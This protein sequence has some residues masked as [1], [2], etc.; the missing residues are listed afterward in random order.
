[1]ERVDVAVVGAGVIGSAAARS[2]AARGVAGVL[3][4][5]FALGHARGSSHGAN[6]V[7]RFSYPDPD[8]VRMAV[9]AREA[10]ARLQADAGEELLLTTGGLDAGPG[11][12]ACAAALAGCGVECHWLGP[13]DLRARF[14]GIAAGPG[15]RMLFQPRAG[16]C[17]AG[18]TVAALQRLAR[19]D[20][21]TS[22]PGTAV[23]AIE[24]E[25]G[26][27]TLRTPAGD[28][29]ARTAIVAAGP[30]S[31]QLLTGA[32]ARA[33]RLTPTVQQVRYFRPRPGAGRWPVL[34]EWPED[35]RVWYTVPQAGGAPGVKVAAHAPGPP[36]DPRDGPFGRIDPAPE[37]AAAG[38]VRERLPGL[39]PVPLAAETCL[40]TMTAD[41]DFVLGRDGQVVV[42]AGCSGH[43]FKFGPLLGEVLAALAL[44]EDP[45]VPL[46]RFALS[47]PALSRPALASDPGD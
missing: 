31:G 7:F 27:V 4:E 47:R 23:S 42:A 6:R 19:R 40:Y 28:I 15:E 30:W 3:L 13:A 21:V 43:A 20:G 22:R 11:A 46:D 25:A 2:L 24:P 9:A 5:Q 45:A 12:E 35:G 44:G 33:P 39:E 26:R 34:L 18:R 16:V 37:E 41:E 36:V 14:P 29:S 32:V 1:M 10:W 17:L 38:Y 8:Y